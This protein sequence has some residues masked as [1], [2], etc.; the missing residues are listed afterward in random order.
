[1]ARATILILNGPNL[2]MLGI[3]EPHIYGSSTLADIEAACAERAGE[4]ELDIDFRQSNHEGQIV[5]WIQ[6]ARGSADGI[7]LNPAGFTHTSV[8]IHDA[9]KAAG[10]PTIEVHL[11]NIHRREEWRHH[12]Y[13]SLVADGVIMG[14]GPQGYLLALD[15]HARLLEAAADKTA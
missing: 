14:L 6:E 7:I 3:R 15:A 9:I 1:M 2:N 13:I 12:S 5:D 4:L 10:V 11:S 8:A